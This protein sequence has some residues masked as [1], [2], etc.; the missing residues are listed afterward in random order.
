MLTILLCRIH[1]STNK[2]LNRRNAYLIDC[3]IR[4]IN[5][6]IRRRLA[7]PSALVAPAAINSMRSAFDAA[8]EPAHPYTPSSNRHS[9]AIGRSPRV[10]T[11]AEKV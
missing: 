7:A 11:F 6:A 4:R 9:F 2:K 3:D 5:A 10:T 1:D 8:R